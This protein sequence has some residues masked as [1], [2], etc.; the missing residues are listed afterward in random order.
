MRKPCRASALRSLVHLAGLGSLASVSLLAAPIAAQHREPTISAEPIPPTR[1]AQQTIVAEGMS[2][3]DELMVRAAITDAWTNYSLLID[4]DGTSLNE[5]AWAELTFTDDFKWVWY[6][7]NGNTTGEVGKDAMARIPAPEVTHRPWKHLPVA[8]KFDEITPTTA[9]TRAIVVMFMVA[10]A[11]EPN[12]PDGA[13]GLS[14]PA[15]PQAG[16]AVYHD[17]WRKE[18]GI[19]LKSSTI[20]Y[21]ANCGWFPQIPSDQEFSCVDPRVLVRP[22]M[23]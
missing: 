20:V 12:T 11:T 23:D 4:G 21:S 10:K 16:Q 7:A 2:K 6:D 19:W 9:R 5:E 22:G 8:V 13:E 14:T 15:V 3:V 1:E 17:T 18:D